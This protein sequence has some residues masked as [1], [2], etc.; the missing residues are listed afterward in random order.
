MKFKHVA[1]LST[2]VFAMC[3]SLV[4]VACS[5]STSPAAPTAPATPPGPTH[6]SSA[7]DSLGLWVGDATSWVLPSIDDATLSG[8]L[9][10]DITSL[11]THLTAGQY[12]ATRTDIANLQTLM[13]STSAAD[14]YSALGPIGVA[15]DVI[16]QALDAA[17]V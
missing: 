10:T 17:G 4:I 14:Y 12:A 6:P 15:L 11:G 3:A 16:Q 5:D 1:Q 13:N 2:V 7:L 8:N 9:Q